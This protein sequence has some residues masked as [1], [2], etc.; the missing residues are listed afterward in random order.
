[1]RK[2]FTICLLCC[3]SMLAYAQTQRPLII[4]EDS[5]G[6]LLE[7]YFPKVNKGLSTHMNLEFASSVAASFTEGDFEEAASSA[8]QPVIGYAPIKAILG[9]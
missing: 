7:K 4:P 2:L 6:S 9:E 8:I 3:V 1:M 5:I